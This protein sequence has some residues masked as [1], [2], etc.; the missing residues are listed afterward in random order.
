MSGFIE[1]HE[2]IRGPSSQEWRTLVERYE[3]QGGI[4]YFSTFGG[5][6]TLSFYTRLRVHSVRSNAYQEHEVRFF[7]LSCVAPLLTHRGFEI[8][9]DAT[10]KGLDPSEGHWNVGGY[11]DPGIEKGL[12]FLNC[13]DYFND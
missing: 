13:L 1:T 7:N 3:R 9:G 4:L 2:I 11:Y 12:L 5:L 10:L 6:Q 8:Q